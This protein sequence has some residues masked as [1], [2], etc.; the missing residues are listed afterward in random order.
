MQ[1]A[2]LSDIKSDRVESVLIEVARPVY[3]HAQH[4][5]CNFLRQVETVAVC[6]VHSFVR[7]HSS[8]KESNRNNRKKTARCHGH[9]GRTGT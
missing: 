8:K 4:G 7:P 6:P 2:L 5:I 3:E 9:Q 1:H